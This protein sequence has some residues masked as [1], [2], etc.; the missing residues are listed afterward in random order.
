MKKIVPII[1]KIISILCIISIIYFSYKIIT[2]K[3]HVDQNKKIK[4]EMK[5][6]IK[7]IKPSSSSNIPEKAKYNIDLKSLREENKDAIGYIKVNN[8]NI[9]YI[10][11]KGKDNSFY[12]NHNF[13]KE[14]NIAGWIFM[15]YRNKLDDNNIIIYGHDTKD[16]SMFGTL[17]NILTKDWYSNKNN[18]E[19][20]FVTEEDTYY[21][22][23][24]SIYTIVPE[25]YYITTSFNNEN[26]YEK[27][28]NTI[29]SRSIYNFNTDLKKEDKILTLSSCIGNYGEKRVVLHARRKEMSTEDNLE[30]KEEKNEKE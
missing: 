20:I 24:F 15:D 17:Q 18:Y 27:F 23:V 10:I 30:K 2:W 12:L 13:K 6:K 1:I 9:D 14:W 11:V 16:G 21:Y 4:E 25:D 28:L 8:T 7:I 29:K 22:E 19:V 26:E 5:D 3:I